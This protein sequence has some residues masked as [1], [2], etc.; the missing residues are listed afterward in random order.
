MGKFLYKNM[1]SIENCLL[2]DHQPSQTLSYFSEQPWFGCYPFSILKN[3]I[4]TKQSPV[5]HPEGNV[6][7]HTLLVVDEAAKRKQFSSNQKV[8][9]WAALL[10]DL[11]KPTTT[12]I[13][14]KK[15]T[16]YDH[17]RV[18]AELV[19]E[20]LSFYL[21]DPSF[22]SD[23]QA[24]VRYHMHLLYVIKNLPFHNIA[25]MKANTKIQDLALLSLCDRLGRTGADV[26]TEL[27][28]IRMFLKIVSDEPLPQW[29]C[30]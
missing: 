30:K 20:F 25:K 27:K 29:C 2:Y 13:T 26:D 6:W 10:H 23:V 11:G 8:F 12:K 24:L 7:N 5:H 17:D 21:S 3:Q 1:E 19:P 14:K 4:D 22:I 15:I 18:G 28:N 9:L 16:A